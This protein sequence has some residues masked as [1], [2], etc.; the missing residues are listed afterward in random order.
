MKKFRTISQ[1]ILLAVFTVL[2]VNISKASSP[3]VD[4]IQSVDS[5]YVDVDQSKGP[6][7]I[8]PVK[9]QQTLYS[10]AKFYQTNVE[11]LKK[12]NPYLYQRGLKVADDLKIPI[13]SENFMVTP[14]TAGLQNQ[15]ATLFYKIKPKDNLFRIAK[16]YFNIPMEEALR[17][18]NKL[19]HNL[20]IGESFVI[21]WVSVKG[22]SP[23]NFQDNV[24][25]PI[26]AGSY[27]LEEK[28]G[29]DYKDRSVV[30]SES[31]TI[32]TESN[33]THSSSSSST[34]T[35]ADTYTTVEEVDYSYPF[36]P[37]KDFKTAQG[38]AIWNKTT[39]RKDIQLYVMHRTARVNSQ[40]E[41]INPMYN[42]S[43]MA[44]VVGNI[45]SGAYGEDVELILSPKTAEYLGAKD[46]RFFVKYKFV[47]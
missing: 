34:S 8:H 15:Y 36:S 41:I 17:N 11:T 46:S 14:P 1:L 4:M 3:F 27:T 28:Y 38:I 40:I 24:E 39:T 29:K 30:S 23:A 31:A 44:K 20:S 32:K 19:S 13:T 22:F 45:P 33:V 6:Y 43:V 12:Y 9:K 18:N 25:D 2:L 47:E 37:G 16:R 42:N 35:S 21:G 10:L 7:L 26:L 5:I